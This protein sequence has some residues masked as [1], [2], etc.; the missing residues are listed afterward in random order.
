LIIFNRFKIFD[1]F[2]FQKWTFYVNIITII[3]FNSQD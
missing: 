2:R 3:L 1:H